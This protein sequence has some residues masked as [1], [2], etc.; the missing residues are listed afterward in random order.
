MEA[1]RDREVLVV[2]VAVIHGGQFLDSLTPKSTS[3]SPRRGRWIHRTLTTVV[4]LTGTKPVRVRE[5]TLSRD[6][7]N[8]YL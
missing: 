5:G 7:L 3:S 1:N 6:E 4:D 2:P 8:R